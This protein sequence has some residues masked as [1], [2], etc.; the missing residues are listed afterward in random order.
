MTGAG[1]LSTRSSVA[2]SSRRRKPV[3]LAILFSKLK[4]LSTP[5]GSGP[6]S[7]GIVQDEQPVAEDSAS[8]IATSSKQSVQNVA[9]ALHGEQVS[10]ASHIASTVGHSHFAEQQDLERGSDPFAKNSNAPDTSET[11]R[12]DFLNHC[13][14]RGRQETLSS[15]Q[16]EYLQDAT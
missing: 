2:G 9:E 10:S 7:K 16:V 13:M 1:R 5:Q 11:G 8:S 12:A 6:A 3:L 15:V 4:T 14:W